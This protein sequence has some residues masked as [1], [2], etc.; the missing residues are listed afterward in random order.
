MSTYL[1]LYQNGVLLRHADSA[2]PAY[3]RFKFSPLSTHPAIFK[4]PE[5]SG[6]KRN[7]YERVDA[8]EEPYF[9]SAHIAQ[10]S[11]NLDFP[12]FDISESSKISLK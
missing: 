2:T 1:P 8:K 10:G 3:A 9:K 5:L 6:E 12:G 7:R 11:H 4:S